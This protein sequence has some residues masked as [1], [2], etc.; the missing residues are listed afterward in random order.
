MISSNGGSWSSLD[1][2]Y[3]NVVKAFKFSKGQ[4]VSCEY[5]HSSKRVKFENI[6][7][8]ETYTLNVNFVEDEM[9]ACVLFYFIDD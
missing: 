3:N 4:T 6:E 8:K 9:Y 5:D 2:S 1:E 7:T